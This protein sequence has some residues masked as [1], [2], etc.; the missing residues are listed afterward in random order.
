VVGIDLVAVEE[1]REALARHGGRYLERVYTPTELRECGTDERRLAARFAAKEATM[2]AL[3]RTDEPIPWCAIGVRTDASG[4]PTL[5][6]TGAAAELARQRGVT[7]LNL[8]FSLKRRL[9][10]AVVLAQRS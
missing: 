4:T 7:G 8:S 6:L 5:E 2:K 1:V 9:A 10:A 3:G